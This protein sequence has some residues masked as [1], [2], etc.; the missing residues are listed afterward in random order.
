MSRLV[1][2]RTRIANK[3]QP[4]MPSGSIGQQLA[5]RGVQSFLS[6]PRAATTSKPDP[7]SR[8]QSLTVRPPDVGGRTS[9]NGVIQ[10]IG[11]RIGGTPA[12]PSP[13]RHVP[14]GQPAI[15]KVSIAQA[16]RLS[17]ALDQAFRK[18]LLGQKLRVRVLPGVS[19]LM[20]AKAE[21]KRLDPRGRLLMRSGL[22]GG[23]KLSPRGTLAQHITAPRSALDRLVNARRARELMGNRGIGLAESGDSTVEATAPD[24][25]AIDAMNKGGQVM[26]SGQPDVESPTLHR[27]EQEQVTT[28]GFGER[29][30]RILYLVGAVVIGWL[31]FRGRA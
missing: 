25:A 16:G 15:P 4:P 3:I 12:I 10:R 23:R 6:N 30:E 21:R 8:P 9:V 27:Q 5:Q 2:A 19:G 14:G 22:E 7:T 13:L 11:N 17:K 24:Q 20:Q 18:D 29:S 31:A 28:S 26:L 1:V